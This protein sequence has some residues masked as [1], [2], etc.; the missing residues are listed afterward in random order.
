MSR[1]LVIKVTAG[2]DAPERCNQA[3]TVAAAAL[4]SGIPV[5]LWLTGESSWFALPGRAKEFSL[6]HAAPLEDLL[7]A[8]LAGGRV[9]LCTQCA[10]RRDITVDDVIDGVRIAGAPAF[11]EEIFAEGARSL[12]Y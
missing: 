6:P 1:S 5:S 12:V 2:A 9:T 8:I 11:I 7:S 3:F 4:A 10:A